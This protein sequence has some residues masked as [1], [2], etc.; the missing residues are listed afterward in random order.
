MLLTRPDPLVQLIDVGTPAHVLAW[1]G[2]RAAVVGVFALFLLQCIGLLPFREQALNQPPQ[3]FLDLIAD[4]LWILQALHQRVVAAADA[5]SQL[6]QLLPIAWIITAPAGLAYIRLG[7]AVG[8]IAEVEEGMAF[9]LLALTPQ[10][11]GQP[12]LDLQ[13]RVAGRSDLTLK[14]APLLQQGRFSLQQLTLG[15]GEA[16]IAIA[17]HADEIGLAALDLLQADA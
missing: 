13:L 11:Q 16:A 8:R 14:P 6:L 17:K 3:V 10:Q 5:L 2:A 1:L 15:R 4:R 12:V 7:I 9:L